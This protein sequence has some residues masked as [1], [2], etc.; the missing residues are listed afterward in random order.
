MRWAASKRIF[1]CSSFACAMRSAPYRA[2]PSQIGM[3]STPWI[4]HAYGSWL[5][6]VSAWFVIENVVE[7]CAG[8]REREL[9][10]G[11]APL[12][13]FEI[14]P[15]PHDVGALVRRT[16]R[17]RAA[18]RLLHLV[19]RDGGR[20]AV[21]LARS[22]REA[23]RLTR[24]AQRFIAGDERRAS[25]CRVLFGAE[26][27]EPRT[28]AEACPSVGEIKPLERAPQADPVDLG[29]ALRRVH[30]D[31]GARDLG[32]GDAPPVLDVEFGDP[33]LELRGADRIPGAGREDGLRRGELQ[34]RDGRKRNEERLNAR[35]GWARWTR[36]G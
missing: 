35:R 8:W 21:A 23:E 24:L 14:A 9:R 17:A 11:D 12:R 22:E 30:R 2:P 29:H 28:A 32:E 4:D 15:R 34:V 19:E 5:G 7:T 6:L 27:V 1:A 33:L 13:D 20:D 31:D 16:R 18:H 36:S 10:V 3:E 25:G 26:H